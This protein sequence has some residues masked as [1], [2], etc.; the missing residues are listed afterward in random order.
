MS[1]KVPG[2]VAV[3]SAGTPVAIYNGSPMVRCRTINIFAD[4]ANTKNVYVGSKSLNVST[5]AGLRSVLAPGQPDQIDATGTG[6]SLNPEDVFIDADV[7]GESAN[8]SF[9]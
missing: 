2:K 5:K 9:T 7:N 4:P 3:A 1:F 8:V 6:R